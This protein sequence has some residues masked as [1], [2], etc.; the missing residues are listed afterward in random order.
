M[1]ELTVT[2]IKQDEEHFLNEIVESKGANLPA[3]IGEVLQ[4]FEFTDW[5]AKAWKTLSDKLL[6]LEDQQEA[7]HSALRSGQQWGV[8]A[9]YAQKRMGE[10][11]R[12]MPKS[13]TR[14]RADGTEI[15]IPEV[16]SKAEQL[17]KAR[18]D[19]YAASDAERIA[20]HPDVLDSVIEKSKES[21]E[22]PTK[23][24]VLREIKHRQ[25][26][27]RARQVNT[28]QKAKAVKERPKIVVDYFDA[29][30]SY[31]HILDLAVEAAKQG[32][33]SEESIGLVE[34]KH[35]ELSTLMAQLEAHIG[36]KK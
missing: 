3:E 20:A 17:G 5:K 18:V 16:G 26:T 14:R 6:R 34:K 9:L 15:D 2:D 29:L 22:I 19:K 7:Y 4:V 30:K 28:E 27:E 33:F 13:I 23:T 24:A 1:N 31:R 32:W 8:A 12:G 10:I 36:D 35:K 11:T 25:A 21:Q